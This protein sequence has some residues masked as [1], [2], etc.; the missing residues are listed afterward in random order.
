VTGTLNHAKTSVSSEIFAGAIIS[1]V[2][3][4]APLRYPLF[5]IL[6]IE[7]ACMSWRRYGTWNCGSRM[8]QWLKHSLQGTCA[9]RY[10]LDSTTCGGS[11]PSYTWVTMGAEEGAGG[12]HHV[13]ERTSHSHESVHAE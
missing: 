7:G 8:P 3:Y 9:P 12:Y 11:S 10:Q 4:L 6:H 1:V 2:Q 13:W 5:E